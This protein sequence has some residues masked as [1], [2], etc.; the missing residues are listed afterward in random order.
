[1]NKVIKIKRKKPNQLMKDIK[2]NNMKEKNK[3]LKIESMLKLE[4]RKIKLELNATIT[5]QTW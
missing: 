4:Y 3:F 5:K 1:M 2:A